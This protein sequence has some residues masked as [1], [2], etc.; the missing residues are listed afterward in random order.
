MELARASACFAQRAANPSL[1]NVAWACEP[2]R[3]RVA[4]LSSVKSS[5]TANAPSAMGFEHTQDW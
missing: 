4:P 1:G 3:N 5:S 2:G